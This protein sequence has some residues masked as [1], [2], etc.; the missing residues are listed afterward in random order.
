M[1]K[2][3]LVSVAVMG[4]LFYT[5]NVS[6]QTK[7][8]TDK[9]VVRT[10]QTTST[11]GKFVDKNKNGI[12]DKHEAKGEKCKSNANCKGSAK[13]IGHQCGQDKAK[14]NCNGTQKRDGSC[15]QKK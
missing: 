9:A 8:A 2:V 6:A 11:Q 4:I 3:I 5:T 15:N 1:K 7:P 14:E 13:G 12:C 10:E